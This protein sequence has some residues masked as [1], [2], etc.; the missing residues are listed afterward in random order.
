MLL[1]TFLVHKN[2]HTNSVSRKKKNRKFVVSYFVKLSDEKSMDEM[3]HQKKV[4]LILDYSAY[5]VTMSR[6]C[7]FDMASN[8]KFSVEF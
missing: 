6:S 5:Y 7:H 8:D 4:P 1:F 3:G 2:K